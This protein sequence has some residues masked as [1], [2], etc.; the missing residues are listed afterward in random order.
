[1][2]PSCPTCTH[3]NP[4]A[5]TLHGRPYTAELCRRMCMV[6]ALARMAWTARYGLPSA[7]EHCGPDARFYVARAV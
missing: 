1:M 6:T 2:I 7:Q 3:Y 4:E 5:T